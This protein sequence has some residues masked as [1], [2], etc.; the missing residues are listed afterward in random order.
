MAAGFLQLLEFSSLARLE[1]L[2]I[3]RGKAA[4][5]INLAVRRRHFNVGFSFS[6]SLSLALSRSL[7]LIN[8]K[9]EEFVIDM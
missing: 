2:E 1:S 8:Q 6:L 9:L 5:R 4:Q 7:T 3:F